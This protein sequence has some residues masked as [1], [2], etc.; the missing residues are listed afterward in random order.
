MYF[1][2]RVIKWDDS[3][4]CIEA[5]VEKIRHFANLL[6]YG[7][8]HLLELLEHSIPSRYFWPL[9]HIYDVN[10]CKDMIEMLQT[11]EKLEAQSTGQAPSTPFFTYKITSAKELNRVQFEG[12]YD[13]PDRKIDKLADMMSKLDTTKECRQGKS[14]SKPNKPYISA[15]RGRGRSYSRGRG[16]QRGRSPNYSY[17]NRRK[18]WGYTRGRGRDFN[19]GR[20]F[21]KGR[22][23][24]Q[25]KFKS[26]NRG[27][28]R[29]KGR[30]PSRSPT[31][32]YA[33]DQGRCYKCHT[34]GHKAVECNVRE[35]HTLNKE[36]VQQKG[37]KWA[38][39]L[40]AG[41]VEDSE[42]E[43]SYESGNM[44]QTLFRDIDD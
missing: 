28:A 4:E 20:N 27:P 29:Y 9:I 39:Q 13:I 10:I 15:G 31:R 38:N 18:N 33:Q 16:Y 36:N 8:A 7:K 37:T 21:N 25:S 22:D 30:S 11:K 26:P 2:W 40:D 5:Y 19:R 41:D 23:N 6:G 14:S 12:N 35:E 3:S 42:E 43:E 17:S 24:Y 32:S 34:F 1:R 44:Y